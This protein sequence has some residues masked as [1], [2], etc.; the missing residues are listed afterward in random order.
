MW[1]YQHKQLIRIS[2]LKIA[3]KLTLQSSFPAN[4]RCKLYLH[5]FFIA[6]NNAHELRYYVKAAS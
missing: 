3:F 2:F 5:L 1:N 4:L 6:A